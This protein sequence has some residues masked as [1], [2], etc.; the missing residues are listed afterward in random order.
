MR[1]P[2]TL[3]LGL[4]SLIVLSSALY[5][6]LG[7]AQYSLFHLAWSVTVLK[8]AITNT[9]SAMLGGIAGFFIGVIYTIKRMEKK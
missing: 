2:K 8:F 5:V 4:L 9:I 6:L 1:R 3:V 7:S